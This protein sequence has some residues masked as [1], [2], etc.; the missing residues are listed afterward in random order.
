MVTNSDEF[1]ESIVRSPRRWTN[2]CVGSRQRRR[3]RRA[4]TD[5]AE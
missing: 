1:G 2:A 5:G 3:R 4:I